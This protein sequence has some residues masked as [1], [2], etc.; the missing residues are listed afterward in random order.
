MCLNPKLQPIGHPLF[1]LLLP[2]LK[3][4]SSSVGLSLQP[5]SNAHLL[6]V[7]LLRLPASNINIFL[8]IFHI[9]SSALLQNPD[10][11]TL[12]LRSLGGSQVDV[13]TLYL[14][15]PV[16]SDMTLAPFQSDP[17]LHTFWVLATAAT[18]CFGSSHLPTP[19]SSCLAHALP[20]SLLPG[21][22]RRLSAESRRSS[23]V[24]NSWFTLNNNC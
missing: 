24:L 17:R 20:L 23:L 9:A 13:Q 5:P 16:P 18:C 8:S 21:S 10:H 4:A 14:A 15:H 11:V 2:H 19:C 22:L 6:Q 1:F 7:V 12:L 3:K